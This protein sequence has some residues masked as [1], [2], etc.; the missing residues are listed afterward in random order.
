MEPF[1]HPCR[2]LYSDAEVYLKTDI[3]AKPLIEQEILVKR[4]D[5]TLMTPVGYSARA[6]I[7]LC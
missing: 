7:T 3:P 4:G 6:V 5:G 1:P 2:L